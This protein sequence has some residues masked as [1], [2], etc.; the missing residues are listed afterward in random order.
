MRLN[1]LNVPRD[2]REA[3]PDLH[4]PLLLQTRQIP[5]EKRQNPRFAFEHELPRAIR[6]AETSAAQP[7]ESPLLRSLIPWRDGTARRPSFDGETVVAVA[8][9]DP[10][11]EMVERTL[12]RQ[13]EATR[14][15]SGRCHTR[16]RW[17]LRRQR[18]KSVLVQ[19]PRARAR[20]QQE[21]LGRQL[22]CR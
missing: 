1:P 21:R 22:R 13:R 10:R 3:A 18:V 14:G 8:H 4:R 2:M 7:V 6:P 20:R 17:Q 12:Q 15:R 9:L 11:R 5:C 19:Q 16:G